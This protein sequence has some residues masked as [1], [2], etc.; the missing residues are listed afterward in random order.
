MLDATD[1]EKEEIV[2]YMEWQAADLK[3]GFVQKVYSELVLNHRPT[4]GTFIPTRI[5]GG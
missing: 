2:G 4:S 1:E 3:V 5:A